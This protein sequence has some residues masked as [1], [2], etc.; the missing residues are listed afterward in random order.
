MK[1]D[2]KIYSQLSPEFSVTSIVTAGTTASINSGEPTKRL[3]ATGASWTG[4]VTSMVDGDGT[5]SQ[6]FTGIAKNES[7]ETA[8]A[9]GTV[10]TWLPLPGIIYECAAKL[11]SAADT[12][13]EIDGL[14]WKRVVFDLTAT[15]WTIDTAAADAAVNAVVI[16]GGDYQTASIQFTYKTTCTALAQ[17][18]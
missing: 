11:A 15:V 10:T 8:S 4:A 5:S 18:A 14:R 13:A 1:N 9:N 2:I 6:A 16:V 12:Q 3:N 7:N 17:I